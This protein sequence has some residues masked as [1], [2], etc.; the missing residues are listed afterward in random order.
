MPT[1]DLQPLLTG[2][3]L[4]LR[5]LRPDDWDELFAVASDPLIWEQHPAS[6]R[7]QEPVFRQFFT[8]ALASG[9]AFAALDRETN[10]IIGSSR[11]FW[12][13]DAKD[14]LE[15][16]WTFL[17]RKYWGGR[18]N[19][20]LKHLMIQHAFTAVDRVVF[21]VGLNN[22]RSRRALEKIGAQPTARTLSRV[23]NGTDATHII[24]ELRR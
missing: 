2:E 4:H 7:Y 9:G 18:Y 13:G 10:R 24:Y 23:M 20:E 21:I 3:L 19:G 11:Y 14:K 12:F 6:D 22:Q 15:I 5:P 1:L 17:A 16:G 8:D